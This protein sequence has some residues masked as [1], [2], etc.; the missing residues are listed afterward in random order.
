MDDWLRDNIACPRHKQKLNLEADHLIC[1]ENDRYLV[2][3]GIPVLLFD[4]GRPSHGHL[5]QTLAQVARIE[6]G[7][8]V[9]SVVPQHKLN[10][11][12]VDDFV[13]QQLPFTC[14]NLYYALQNGLTRYPFPEIRLPPGN[15]RPLLDIGS[16]WGR[17]TIPAA[18]KG[19]KA[20]GMDP[21]LEGAI[22]AK[23]IAAQLGVK[24][25]FVVADALFLPFV[26][27]AFDLVFSYSVFQHLLKKNVIKSLADISRVTKAG[28]AIVIQMPNRFGVRCLYHQ[29]RNVFRPQQEGSGVFYWTPAE[30][31]RE[32]SYQFG[33]TEM[34][35]DC[36]FGLN[37]QAADADM[38]PFLH[39]L[40]INA[41]ETLR[42]ASSVVT[43]LRNVADSLYVSSVN[44]KPS[45]DQ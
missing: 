37:L 3:D 1:P 9:E 33:E 2:V 40:A 32:F 44:K 34:S 7:E 5:K 39:R 31:R 12:G 30:L 6:A 45:G 28:G 14:G 11:H 26:D 4:D 36:F 24:A 35:V 42:S 13:D 20:V 25:D 41:S 43:P 27:D 21:H 17:W 16:S 23:R 22:A 29:A 18:K 15:G 38:M 10:E 19:Y 8:P